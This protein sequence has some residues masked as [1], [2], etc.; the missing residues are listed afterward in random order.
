MTDAV[1]A[2]ERAL[3]ATLDESERT[4][5]IAYFKP[6]VVSAG[7]ELHLGDITVP[8][9]RDSLIVFVDLE[10]AVN[11]SHSCCYLV[12]PV[13]G[14]VSRIDARMPP[15]LKAGGGGWRLL[16]RGPLAPEWA[17]AVR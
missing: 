16:R 14:A 17:V 5:S 13:V 1:D 8:V 6:T 2:L 12:V 10:P 11:W 9:A 15:F 3:D 7:T 4:G